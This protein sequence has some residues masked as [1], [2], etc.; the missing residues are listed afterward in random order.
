MQAC[1]ERDHGGD[2]AHKLVTV[3]GGSVGETRTCPLGSTKVI[4]SKQRTLA[5]DRSS[6]RER[7]WRIKGV[8]TTAVQ[9]QRIVSA[10]AVNVASGWMFRALVTV[11]WWT[12]HPAACSG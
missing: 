9:V 4:A 11:P 6:S 1:C 12:A 7:A 10:K 5:F 3:R 2:G 8:S